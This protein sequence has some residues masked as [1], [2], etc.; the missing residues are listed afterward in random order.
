[1]SNLL[2]HIRNGKLACYKYVYR[3]CIGKNMNPR[4][5]EQKIKFLDE[6]FKKELEE[7]TFDI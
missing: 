5:F 6:S 3:R 2:F 7:L 4:K 1:M